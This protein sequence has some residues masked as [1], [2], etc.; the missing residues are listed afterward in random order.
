[1]QTLRRTVLLSA[2]AV[3]C[4]LTASPSLA[5]DSCRVLLC[6]P[7][8]WQGHPDCKP[9]VPDYL[10]CL[11]RRGCTLSCPE[12]GGAAIQWASAA[13]CPPQ[14]LRE[15]VNGGSYCTKSGT[16][17][18]PWQGQPDYV[19]VWFTTGGY[20]EP[21]FEYSAAARAALGEFASPQFD[22]DYEQ[23]LRTRP[24][25]PCAS[26]FTDQCGNQ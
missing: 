4:V 19:R 26:P 6:L 13:N 3:S 24:A 22:L 7:G 21:V 15:T 17:S 20:E 12:A 1:M 8:A 14:Y 9:D 10:R 18:I 23:W 2:T 11:G 16:L 5:Y 25:D